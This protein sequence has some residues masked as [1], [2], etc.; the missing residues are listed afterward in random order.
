MRLLLALLLCAAAG[1][2]TPVPAPVTDPE[3][4]KKLDAEYESR[5]HGKGGQKRP[6]E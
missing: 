6:R 5:L 4:M 1:C 2:G 3:A